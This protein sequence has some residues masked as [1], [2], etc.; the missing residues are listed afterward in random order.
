MKKSKV[1]PPGSKPQQPEKGCAPDW[2]DR[3]PKCR[4]PIKEEKE[5]CPACG[6][7]LWRPNIPSLIGG[8]LLV[9]GD[10]ERE[11]KPVTVL[12]VDL[13]VWADASAGA[14]HREFYKVVESCFG[15]LV[16]E[17][18]KYG[19]TVAKV[20]G[21][22]L[23]ALF[24]APVAREDHAAQAC[25][26]ALA[27]KKSLNDFAVKSGKEPGIGSLT[28]MM[29]N[30][31]L[32]L[33][34]AV[35]AALKIDPDEIDGA[36]DLIAGI[37]PEL[38]PGII[39]V[40]KTT[41]DLA[42][43]FF[44]FSAAPLLMAPLR[45]EPQEIYELIDVS[46]KTGLKAKG[47][48]R[49]SKFVGRDKEMAIL[50][51][52]L[53]QAA[54]GRGRVLGVGGDAGVG[55]SRLI[56]EF[57]KSLPQE[58]GYLE[59]RCVH[60]SDF[61][62]Y[63]PLLQMLRSHLRIADGDGERSVKNKIKKRIGLGDDGLFSP[64]H[65]LLSLRRGEEDKP[66][67]GSLQKRDRIFDAIEALLTVESRKHP[68]VLVIEDIHWIDRTSE[69]FV[70]RFNGR[71]HDLRILFL[72]TYRPEYSDSAL[73][74]GNL[75]EMHLDQLE[76]KASIELVQSIIGNRKDLYPQAP[77]VIMGKAGGNPLFVEELTRSLLESGSIRAVGGKFVLD[78]PNGTIP[79]TIRGVI[80]ARM[81][82]LGKDAKNALQAASVIGARFHE[83]L[84]QEI[85]G[86]GGTLGPMLSKLQ[87]LEFI[88]EK[89]PSHTVEY[90]FKHAIIREVAYESLALS[91]RRKIHREIGNAA[92][93]IYSERLED[94]YEIL[95]HHYSIGQ[96][97]EKAYKYLRLAGDKA[98]RYNSPWEAFHFYCEAHEALK[99]GPDTDENKRERIGLILLAD[100]NGA[101][102]DAP[103]VALS[104]LEEG[105]RLS[106]EL[107]DA[108]S[109]AAF[110]RR[111]YVYYQIRGLSDQA[112][113]YTA[114]CFEHAKNINP[115]DLNAQNLES[116]VPMVFEY[117]VY[118]LLS[119]KK[120]GV[121]PT[122]AKVID[123]IER[124]HYEQRSFG[125][126]L[127]PYICLLA[128]QTAFH[129]M[130]GEFEEARSSYTRGLKAT[131]EGTDLLSRG[132]LELTFGVGNFEKGDWQAAVGPLQKVNEFYA[133]LNLGG[134]WMATFWSALGSVSYLAGNL[135]LARDQLEKA[136]Q[137]HFEAGSMFHVSRAFAVLSLTHLEL[138]DVQGA[139]KCAESAIHWSQKLKER[140]LEGMALMFAGRILGKS[141]RLQ[142]AKAESMILAGVERVKELSM[143]AYVARGLLYLGELYLDTGQK[144][145][146][147]KHLR[148]AD[149]AFQ[150]MGM[151]YWSSKAR[152]LLARIS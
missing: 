137:I 140:D 62:P 132:W 37:E 48:K 131:N 82:R 4:S 7:E 127:N 38:R 67:A 41:F 84:L 147:H 54:S 90:E 29:L 8:R 36:E 46:F 15:L 69:E 59:G 89:P 33:V 107:S 121:S 72:V 31:G 28:R 116:L 65:G 133:K 16:N 150:D 120:A 151:D 39:A 152:C 80:S 11:R 92:E 64:L 88:F 71:I 136:I 13:A 2:V 22:G 103:T 134:N 14:D 99:K 98:N 19:G 32:V 77:E 145:R 81:D 17:I 57:E 58:Y 111:L 76:Q 49:L 45:D 138:G 35:P 143:K 68:L 106:Q 56:M 42:T 1:A 6:S 112:M 114:R 123:A 100:W 10:A 115:A 78:G 23:T 20:A 83:H 51:D 104:L 130:L 40:G 79:E 74:R 53:Q 50:K 60:T 47:V 109:L 44:E 43:D 149:A 110:H 21:N 61:S 95:G 63:F 113:K 128:L 125:L 102:I 118:V 75:G 97:W 126:T 117:C 66:A 70:A 94:F 122:I 26:A 124:E 87:R 25:R 5:F 3:C 91:R 105:E 119:G 27:V 139:R 135:G 24:G 101:C 142:S 108:D 141:S 18:E 34:S 55:K 148:K 9:T 73:A 30:S 144:K 12:F 86:N 85:L 93:E 96:Q 52:A 129:A 146:A